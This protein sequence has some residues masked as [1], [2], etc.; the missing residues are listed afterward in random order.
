MCTVIVDIQEEGQ[1]FKIVKFDTND[2]DV[3][4]DGELLHSGC[5]ADVAMEALANYTS[6]FIQIAKPFL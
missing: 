1:S 2:Y 5:G 4:K 3:S 6:H